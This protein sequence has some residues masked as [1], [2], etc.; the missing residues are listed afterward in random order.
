MLKYAIN[1]APSKRKLPFYGLQHVLTMLG[2]TIAVP[3]IVAGAFGLSD[4][5]TALFISNVLIAMGIATLIQI[6]LGT[7]LPI[8]QGSSFAFLPA[9]LYVGSVHPGAEGLQYVFGAV[10]LGG[11]FQASLGFSRVAGMLQ[12]VLTPVVIGPTIMVIG[13]SLF[14]AGGSQ[15]STNWGVAFATIAL[16]LVFSFGLRVF[17]NNKSDPGI[18]RTLGAFPIMIA[19]VLIWG[20]CLMLGLT[21]VID[22]DNAANVDLSVVE[23]VPYLKTNGFFFPWGMPKFDLSVLIIFLIAYAV[24]TIESIG[25]YN[26]INEI[27][28][29][30][31]TELTPEIVNRGVFAEGLGCTIAGVLGANP[32]TSYSE[33]IGVVGITGVASRLVVVVGALILIGAGFVPKFGALLATIPSP[34]MGGLYCVLFGMIAG[35]GLRYAA[36]T[37]LDSMR[38]IS[39]IGFSLFLGFA[40]PSAFAD[41]AVKDALIN[42]LG[43]GGGDILLGIVTSNMAITAISA[44]ILDNAL[45][46]D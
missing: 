46:R 24:S 3:T 37:N 23:S 9:M 35:V 22:A 38:N 1:E 2:A 42:A 20:I 7:K 4:A 14:S 19:I 10:I 36:K 41:A 12:K 25:D 21:G 27:A 43:Q 30:E 32:T 34:I 44:L 31:P 11:I 15:A 33:N 6:F 18:A 16:I 29:R 28:S 8:V 13:L 26:A 40:L 5:E 45:D 17:K 39:V